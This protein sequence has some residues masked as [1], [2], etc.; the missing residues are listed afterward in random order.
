MRS[1]LSL[2]NRP[3]AARDLPGA[4]KRT[5]AAIVVLL[6]AGCA[7][8]PVAPFQ[9][10]SQSLVELNQGSDK[11]LADLVPLSENRF[12]RELAAELE[13]GAGEGEEESLLESMQIATDPSTPFTLKAAPLFLKMEQFKMGV[14]QVTGSLVTYSQLLL[15][16]ADPELLSQETFDDLA[17]DLNAHAFN[18]MSTMNTDPSEQAQSDVAL[19]SQL[20][21]A[22]TQAYL[23]SERKD[24]LIDAIEANQA[25]VAN[26]AKEM[27]RAVVIIAQATVNEYMADY[28]VLARKVIVKSTR[29]RAIDELIS[30]NRN[31]IRQIKTLHALHQAYGKI[32][33]AHAELAKAVAE[34]KREL[35]TIINV[36]ETGK[37]LQ[38]GYDQ[39]LAANKAES[40]QAKADRASAQADALEAE[41]EAAAL[42]SATANLA[43]VHARIEADADPDNE[44][45]ERV[46]KELEEAAKALKEEAEKKKASARELRAAADIV[47]QRADEIKKRLIGAP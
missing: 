46:A 19:F 21:I 15:Q 29:E 10:F 5:M 4:T 16:L 9:A 23:Q 36:M 7:S 35:S 2:F 41:A 45:K 31:H 17:T 42:R 38:A 27:Q 13:E 11:A 37:R 1:I 32:P 44:D 22:A 25:G 26:L 6:T 47:Q 34:P 33:A 12:K 24:D 39:A 8:V 40:A 30:L 20:A 28:L 18:A 43:A 3:R 14:N